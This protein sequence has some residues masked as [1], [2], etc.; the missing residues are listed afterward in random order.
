MTQKDTISRPKARIPRGLRDIDADEARGLSAMLAVVSQVYESWGFEPLDTAILEYADALGH[1]LPD[2]DRPNEG[3]F[4]LQ[5]DDGQWLALRYDLTAPLARY[6]AAHY[7][8]LPKPFRRYQWG[9]VFRNEKPGP[10]RFRQFM[11][12]DADSVGAPVMVADAELC[13][14]AAACMESL[15]V[16]R[17]RY[18][19][20]LNNRQ[21]LDGVLE[22][23]GLDPKA[24]DFAARRL[25]VLRAI[26]KWDRL[27]EK[28]VADL[29]GEGRK[30]AS[31][32]FTPGACLD[33]GSIDK[34][35]AFVRLKGV[36]HGNLCDQLE[37]LVGNSET[38]RAGVMALREI[39]D[40]LP[41]FGCDARC[42]AIDPSIVRGLGY[43]TGPVFEVRLGEGRVQDAV[44]GGGRYDDMVRRFK[45]ISVPAVGFSMGV[46]R[47]YA[48]LQEQKMKKENLLQGPVVVLRLG[49]ENAAS[50]VTMAQELRVAGIRAEAY[51]GG[52]G[53]RAQLK[54]ADKR[55]APIAV[56]E[57]DDERARQSVTV[58]DL[59][60]G[61][62]LA[63]D[64]SD[65]EEW[66]TTGV[67][68]TSLPRAQ[69]VEGVRAILDRQ[70]ETAS[71]VDSTS[72]V[73]SDKCT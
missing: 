12:I 25:G 52:G 18:V 16:P 19:V 22:T 1:F 31:G 6:V 53:M 42:V 27:G 21:V 5:D 58:K 47:L 9:T 62:S 69:L 61:A 28:G 66:R 14:V 35:L 23:L 45:G 8:E 50:S 34:V 63:I 17:R 3:V 37:A 10:G 48:A 59:A 7:D 55:A 71:S 51:V 11:Q 54:Y 64:I 41:A 72:T 30:D 39:I 60:L 26:D 49:E 65:N 36:S 13:A 33:A 68:Q 38:G 20:G 15:G 70:R 24:A 57:G 46:S 73:S 56:I 67:A 43:Y 44:G 4:A 40:L 2:Q 29:L 32:D